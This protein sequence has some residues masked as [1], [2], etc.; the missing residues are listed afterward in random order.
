[1]ASQ[2]E[3]KKTPET[4]ALT[5]DEDGVVDFLSG[6]DTKPVNSA[7]YDAD[8]NYT[9]GRSSEELDSLADD[10]EHRGSKRDSDIKK[11]RHE[12]Y[13]GLSLEE[14][15]KLAGPIVRDTSGAAE[16]FDANGQA[17]DVKSFNSHYPSSSGGYSLAH[18]MSMINKELKKGE[19]I[20]LDTTNLYEEH[21]EELINELEELG[22]M[23]WILVWP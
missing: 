4:G 22:L 6:A 1:M 7:M 18:C 2:T 16:F 17:W 19:N 5:P 20:I 13:V 14:S 8:G 11:G 10:P 3:T 21:M 12:R 15:G 9:G 23:D